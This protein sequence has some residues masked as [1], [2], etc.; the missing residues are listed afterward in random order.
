M[1]GNVSAVD[2]DSTAPGEGY[3]KRLADSR[4]NKFGYLWNGAMTVPDGYPP[5]TKQ[6]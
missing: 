2:P 6:I 1:Q 4:E 3:D 5:Q